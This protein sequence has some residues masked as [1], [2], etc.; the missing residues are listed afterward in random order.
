MAFLSFLSFSMAG[1]VDVQSA[2]E[3]G[4]NLLASYKAAKD[5]DLRL[6][7]TYKSEQGIPLFYLFNTT[8]CY[9]IV[10]ADDCATPILAYSDEGPVSP[11]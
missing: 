1:P 10:S 7:Y 6:A 2:R 8:Q 5:V 9:V 11:D 3:I 4:R